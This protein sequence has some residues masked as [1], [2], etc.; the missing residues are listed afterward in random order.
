M[1]KS[2]LITLILCSLGI[3]GCMQTAQAPVA[4]GLSQQDLNALTSVYQLV[5]FDL[6]TCQ[7]LPANSP[8]PTIAISDKICADAKVYQQ[9]LSDVAK[10]RSVALPDQMRYDLEARLIAMT[11]HASPNEN[12]EYLRDEIDSHEEA[13]AIFQDESTKGS[14][15]QI[16]N[17]DKAAIPLVQSNLDALRTALAAAPEPKT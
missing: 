4:S 9:R 6:A 5:Q 16:I 13:L 10:A 12:I 2:S 7:R 1:N 11:Y 15:A 14:D 8:A 3:S 17:I